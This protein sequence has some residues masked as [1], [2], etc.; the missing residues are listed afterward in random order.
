MRHV[1]TQAKSDRKK[2]PF[3]RQ[4]DRGRRRNAQRR[5]LVSAAFR[6]IARH[7][8]NL[9]MDQIAAEAGITKPILYRHFGD[10]SGLVAAVTLRYLEEIRAELAKVDPALPLRERTRQQFELGLSY[11]ER[12]PGLLEFIDRERGFEESEARE[13]REH[14]E[15]IL[16]LV[17][18]LIGAR[19]LDVR[20]ARPLAHGISGMI[21]RSTLAWLRDSGRSPRDALSRE[22]M[23]EAA[24]TLLFDGLEKL[25]GG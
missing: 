11:L 7:G 13:G 24:T 25:I 16:A 21:I 8:P 23:S 15:R 2:V 1:G 19:G 4:T 20:L 22:A 6:A 3:K 18:S 17:R 12:R 14:V 5:A 10:K 9:S